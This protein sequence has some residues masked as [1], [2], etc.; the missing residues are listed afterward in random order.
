VF[1]KVHKGLEY[2]EFSLPAFDLCSRLFA[3]VVVKTVVIY[4]PLKTLNLTF[5]HFQEKQGTA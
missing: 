5:V 3:W 2:R 1:A 4:R